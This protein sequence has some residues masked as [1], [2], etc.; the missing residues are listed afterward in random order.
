[1]FIILTNYDRGNFIVHLE[2]DAV[3]SHVSGITWDWY[4]AGSVLYRVI[5]TNELL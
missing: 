5:V 1:M 4:P 3:L 2:L